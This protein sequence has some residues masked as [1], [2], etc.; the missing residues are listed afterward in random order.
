M[1]NES[2]REISP[3]SPNRAFEDIVNDLNKK[4]SQLEGLA[5]RYSFVQTQL[6][7]LYSGLGFTKPFTTRV[8]LGN[9]SSDYTNW[10][11]FQVDNGYN[12]WKY[13]VT[14]YA[15]DSRNQLRFDYQIV[16]FQG[17]ASV[18]GDSSFT[19][20]KIFSGAT[21][22]DHTSEAGTAQGT[23]FTILRD[24]NETLWVGNANVFSGLDIGMFRQGAGYSLQYLYS[25]AGSIFSGTGATTILREDN[26]NGLRND[27]TIMFD[28]PG[29]WAQTEMNGTTAFWI[30][31]NSLTNPSLIAQ[32]YYV[33][34]TNNVANML[35]LSQ[36]EITDEQKIKWC[37]FSQNA[38]ATIRSD[39]DPSY[40]GISFL[41][42]GSDASLRQLFFTKKHLFEM[43][44]KSASF[45]PAA[46]AKVEHFSIMISGGDAQLPYSGRLMHITDLGSSYKYRIKRAWG[47]N[48]KPPSKGIDFRILPTEDVNG[49]AYETLTFSSGSY[50][51]SL[52]N[53]VTEIPNSTGYGLFLWAKDGMD[54]MANTYI[55]V[56]LEPLVT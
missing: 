19:A 41:R 42:S 46:I 3:V 7:E 37:S 6:D 24:S 44:H 5:K 31:I 35:K 2:Q 55:T 17:E 18:E 40:E 39:G 13:P 56:E 49:S 53:G 32:C 8:A 11:C 12:I 33:K 26:T 29:D 51:A 23:P 15:Y 34:P 43:D 25:K 47:W 45:A 1:A 50:T 10:T 20:A 9:T 28:V 27:G 36:I 48:G 54:I 4:L 14:D 30:G 21:W 16:D 52:T 38:Y 22:T